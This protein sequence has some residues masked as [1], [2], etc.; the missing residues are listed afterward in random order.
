M[1]ALELEVNFVRGVLPPTIQVLR[2]AI[3]NER[4]TKA[5]VDKESDIYGAVGE[6]MQES[7]GVLTEVSLHMR[8]EP[9]GDPTWRMRLSS[10]AHHSRIRLILGPWTSSESI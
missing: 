1:T 6:L 7:D 2:V 9:F 4:W 8:P 10:A 5:F 3:R